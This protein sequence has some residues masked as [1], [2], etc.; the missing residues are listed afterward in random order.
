MSWHWVLIGVLAV[1]MA[2]HM[3]RVNGLR[4]CPSHTAL[5]AERD[6]QVEADIDAMMALPTDRAL[7]CD[8]FFRAVRDELDREAVD[9][10]GARAN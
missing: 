5:L 8:Q 3:G 6:K 4:Q 7:I 2:F 10:Q 9:D 1:A